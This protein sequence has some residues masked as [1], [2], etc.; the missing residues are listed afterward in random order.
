M[1]AY[2]GK[3][4]FVMLKI[5]LSELV[6]E[7]SG[8]IRTSIPKLVQVRLELSPN[9]PVIEA[10]PSQ[11]QQLVMN[12]VV[13]GAEAIGEASTGTV[14]VTTELQI[15]DEH[16]ISH[17]LVGDLV[18]P[19]KYVALEVHDTGSGMTD[20]TK[21]RIFDPFFTTK[22]TG[23]GLGLAAVLGIVRSHKGTI[24]VYSSLGKG[25]TFKVLLPAADGTVVHAEPAAAENLRGTG[26][27]LVVDD[28]DIV[29]NMAKRVLQRYGYTVILAEDGKAGVE[30]LGQK[31]SDISLVLLDMTMP[32]MNG[33]EAFRQIRM[34]S[35]DVRVI[36]SSG[37]SEV[38]AIRR[39]SNKGL[40][41]FIQKTYTSVEL[42]RKV[43]TVL[44]SERA[45]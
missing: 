4:R 10:D 33:E 13:N 30:A 24:R 40:A 22:F 45:E 37:Y 7:I 5:D 38:E 8:L 6:H 41:G 27:I 28:E 26:T 14:L 11:I 2:A 44:T 39:F 3:G 34:I 12:L 31:K 43:K 29:R 25:S 19:G 15:V 36:L 20:A 18:E 42:A 9:L 17:N 23:R 16:Y 32:V 35:P 1:L 21:A